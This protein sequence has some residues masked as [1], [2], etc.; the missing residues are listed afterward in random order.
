MVRTRIV[1]LDREQKSLARGGKVTLYVYKVT[2]TANLVCINERVVVRTR[3]VSLAE[4]PRPGREG[5]YN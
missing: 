1:S 5:L 3:I 4:V 2:C